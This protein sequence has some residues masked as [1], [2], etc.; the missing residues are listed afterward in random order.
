MWISFSKKN[1]AVDRIAISSDRKKQLSEAEMKHDDKMCLECLWMFI[2]TVINY[3]G[4]N[5]K[6][7][8][9]TSLTN[10]ANVNT[11][12]CLAVIYMESIH[13]SFF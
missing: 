13:A 3:P 8:E 4:Y 10:I 2:N 9:A 1:D 7:I 6:Y 11:T 5:D 12:F